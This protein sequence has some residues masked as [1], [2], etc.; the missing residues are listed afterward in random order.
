M[1]KVRIG[2]NDDGT[3]RFHYTLTEAEVADGYVAFMTGPIAGTVSLA[4]GTAYDV[5]DD[6]VAAKAEHVGELHVAIHRMHHAAG[7]FLDVPVPAL[8]DVALPE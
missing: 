4:D 3:A 8:E 5:T 1:D 2:D 6:F 7:R